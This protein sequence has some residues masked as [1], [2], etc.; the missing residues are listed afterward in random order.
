MTRKPINRPSRNRTPVHG[1]VFAAAFLLAA[2]VFGTILPH[3]VHGANVEVSDIFLMI[4]DYTNDSTVDA[5]AAL[6]FT[7]A[8]IPPPAQVDDVFFEWFAPNGTMVFQQ[9]VDPN[10]FAWAQS[11]YRVTAVGRW[12]LNAT[13]T[14]NTSVHESLSFSVLPN[15]WGPLPVML[16]FTTVVGRS[17]LLTILPGTQIR[18]PR[19]GA[20]RVQGKL[21]ASGTPAQP[22]VFTSNAASPAA[23]DWNVLSFLETADNSSEVS[24]AR[25]QYSDGGIRIKGSSP[26]ISNVTFTNNLMSNINAQNS[27]SSIRD[28]TITGGGY[29]MSLVGSDVEVSFATISDASSG[30]L[31]QGPGGH[32]SDIVVN[33]CTQVGIYAYNA[34]AS[35]EN[36]DL[37][38]NNVGIEA[39]NSTFRAENIMVN[40]GQIAVE[41]TAGSRV[42]ISNS[43][44]T[45]IGLRHYSASGGSEIVA[46]NVSLTPPS[47]LRREVLDTSTILIQN[48]LW[49]RARSHDS[50]LALE[51]AMIKIYHNGILSSSVL[52]DFRGEVGPLV[53]TYGQY[54]ASTFRG[55]L[56][57]V[58]VDLTGFAFADNDRIVSMA[59]SHVETFN[60]SVFDYDHDGNPDFNDTDDDNDGLSDQ[61]ELAI[62]TN[63]LN[64][65]TDGDKMPDKWEF[66]EQLNP[67]DPSDAAGDLDG[68]GLSN[69]GEYQQGTDPRN[70]DSDGDGM[71]DGWEVRYGFNPN[72]SSDANQDADGDGYTNL[73]EYQNGTNPRSP[74]SRPPFN[75]NLGLLGAGDYWPILLLPIAA[76]CAEVVM[77]S[78]LSFFAVPRRKR[79]KMPPLEPAKKD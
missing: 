45:D 62:G 74:E 48:H 63:P 8:P 50:G 4:D 36:A 6:N 2:L 12:T 11:S 46:R 60:G 19:G 49:I 76:L 41:A 3:G 51:G 42:W 75:P 77:V 58:R 40:R 27:G 26:S 10:D 33:G 17:G 66:D 78:M 5:W 24:E 73:E 59:S 64:P 16:N 30:I 7:D 53:L 31:L 20:L 34:S 35:I 68:D 9:T 61:T 39:Y 52:T 67:L 25:V 15:V 69:L 70:P 65:D 22:I 28:V 32:V 14:T 47:P 38:D 44:M 29:G 37:S 56:N 13:Y 72:N 43:T 18:F 57:T 71:P 23:G 21:I 79:R 54:N 55:E 1:R